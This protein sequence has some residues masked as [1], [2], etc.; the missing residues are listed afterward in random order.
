MA[1]LIVT[2]VA[3]GATRIREKQKEKK[4]ARR[5]ESQQFERVPHN[6]LKDA[7]TQ[8]ELDLVNK[9]TDE[10]TRNKEIAGLA[11]ESEPLW[12]AAQDTE[13]HGQ[14]F[15]ATVSNKTDP[16]LPPC[17]QWT[18]GSADNRQVGTKHHRSSGSSKLDDEK[19]RRKEEKNVCIEKDTHSTSDP[20]VATEYEISGQ[21]K[22][23]KRDSGTAEADSKTRLPRSERDTLV[24]KAEIAKQEAIQDQVE[25]LISGRV[26]W[27]EPQQR[28]DEDDIRIRKLSEVGKAQTME[29]SKSCRGSRRAE[30]RISGSC[31]G[32]KRSQ[33][34]CAGRRPQR[35][36]TWF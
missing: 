22:H 17:V 1:S 15:K 28:N 11:L 27:I 25:K 8:R 23:V 21:G 7:K 33:G 9:L 32:R 5:K 18:S 29:P 31:Q 19:R 26:A 36:E 14:H 16:D 2:S 4:E 34:G 6:D 20:P 3:V 24:I 10:K 12:K 30:G 13:P 35:A